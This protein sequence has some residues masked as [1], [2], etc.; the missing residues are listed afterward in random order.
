[1]TPKTFGNM[2]PQNNL[3]VTV[4]NPVLKTFNKREFDRY[5]DLNR[6]TRLK[7][8]WITINNNKIA[9]ASDFNIVQ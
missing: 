3:R 5:Y 2:L 1:M 7:F 4:K 6:V 9:Y 8:K